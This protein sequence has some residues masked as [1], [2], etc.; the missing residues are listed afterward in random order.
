MTASNSENLCPD[1]E[2]NLGAE[3]SPIIPDHEMLRP[4]GAGSYGHVWLARSATG[5]FRAV[6]IVCR[7]SFDSDRPY[8]REF[9][10]I[11]RFEPISHARESQVDV[12]HVGRNDAAGFFYYIME[13]ADDVRPECRVPNGRQ[14]G[15]PGL[16]S[17]EQ[18][19]PRTLKHELRQ[20]G[21]LPVE[22][23]LEIALSLTRASRKDH[24]FFAIPATSM[25]NIV[26]CESAID[27]ISCHALHPQYRCLSTAGARPNPSWLAELVD[28]AYQIYCGF[29][30]DETG[31]AMAH[32]MMALYPSIQRLCP[33]RK[34]WNDVLRLS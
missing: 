1:T 33:S 10:G 29:D 31:E 18:Y 17:V 11:K 9:E 5:S 25:D 22:E 4:I 12:F 28:P 20:R 16:E 21:L 15:C 6:K 3:A 14:I 24:G 32:S 26:L 13:L 30:L 8:E 19:S 34:D 27:A 23:L 2:G 7:R